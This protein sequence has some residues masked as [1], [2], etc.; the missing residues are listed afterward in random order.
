MSILEDSARWIQEIL[1]K[2]SILAAEDANLRHGLSVII[3]HMQE[4]HLENSQLRELLRLQIPFQQQLQVLQVEKNLLDSALSITSSVSQSLKT[5]IRRSRLDGMGA[6]RIVS[7]LSNNSLVSDN[8]AECAACGE[9]DG[10]NKRSL[11]PPPKNGYGWLCQR[12][13]WGC[14]IATEEKNKLEAKRE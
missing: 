6:D 7:L 3:D 11:T 9:V 1:H 5:D 2:L 14:L 13:D 4:L 12:C 8:S 10:R